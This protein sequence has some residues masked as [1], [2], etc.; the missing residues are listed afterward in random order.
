MSGSTLM[1]LGTRALSANY[2]A[3]QTVS[4]NIANANTPGYSRQSVQFQSAEGQYSG[5]GF[6]GRGADATTVTRAHSDFLTREAATTRSLAAAD[7]ARSSQLQQLERSFRTGESGIGAAAG[8][9]FNAFVDVATNPQDASARQSALGAADDLAARFRSAADQIDALQTGVGSELR[10]GVASANALTTRIAQLNQQ[11]SAVKGSGHEPNDLL[12]QRDTAVNELS[13][14]V[15]VTTVPADD[16]SLSVFL[17]GGQRLV[18][19]NSAGTLATVADPFEPEKLQ[20]GMVES[21]VARALPPGYLTGGRL[22]GLLAFQNK[23][24][25]DARNL[26][27]QL[28]SAIGGAVNRQQ[29]LGLDLTQPA[30]AGAPLYSVGTPRVAPASTNAAI[31]G[32]AVASYVDATGTRVPS[33]SL[34][35]VDASALRASDYTLEPDPYGVA[36]TFQIT[37]AS[38]GLK[39]TVADGTVIDGFRVGIAAPLPLAGD[40]FLLQ[41]VGS[42]ARDM[43]RVLDDPK[44]LAAAAPVT[45]ATAIGNTGTATV[46]AIAADGTPLD[47]N[48]TATLAFSDDAGH[49]TWTLVDATGAKPTVSGTG[50][51][52]PDRPIELNGWTLDLDG[53]PRGGDTV[54]VKKTEFPA[55]DNGN[56]KAM[57]ALRDAPIVG[58]TVQADGSVTAGSAVTDAYADAIADIGVRVQIAASTA[59]QSAAQAASAK[60]AESSKSGVNLDEEAARLIEYQQSYQAAAK[61]LQ[62]AQS[63]F[64]SLLRATGG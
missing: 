57:L 17:Q 9:L 25:N 24:V 22:A 15:Q 2:A 16:G 55:G 46:S 45:A 36:G 3:L 59:G 35:V 50:S 53:V 12:D 33:V 47:P 48:L 8:Q 4:H 39:R 58:R 7:D 37:R 62:V 54:T 11:I 26:L 63:I 32:K 5:S 29:S 18:L 40:R 56:A 14:Y 52:Q 64:D 30:K 10:T 60:S 42:A 6:Y 20:I 28:A 51:W 44:G 49:Y 61:M 13:E 27:G 41:P 43:R 19:G 23:D 1:T 38:D 34:A 31:D 21:G